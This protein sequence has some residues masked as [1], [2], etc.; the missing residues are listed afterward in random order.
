MASLSGG[1]SRI[2]H[3][4]VAPSTALI[5][6]YLSAIMSQ[7]AA[8]RR[9]TL[10]LRPD[11]SSC[12][13]ALLKQLVWKY[14]GAGVPVHAVHSA[15]GGMSWWAS[16]ANRIRVVESAVDKCLDQTERALVYMYA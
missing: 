14:P 7:A 5:Q 9:I 3:T 13:L 16:F 4:P 2:T 6:V 11:T 15:I 1:S 8:E 12:T 10:G